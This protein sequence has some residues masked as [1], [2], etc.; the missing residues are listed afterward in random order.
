MSLSTKRKLLSAVTGTCYDCGRINVLELDHVDVAGYHYR[1]AWADCNCLWNDDPDC[2][3]YNF[4]ITAQHV[5]Q[6]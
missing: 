6:D 1:A 3:V 2:N 5:P 4:D